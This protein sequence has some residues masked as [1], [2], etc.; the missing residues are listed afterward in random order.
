MQ[1]PALNKL[2]QE[3]PP[4]GKRFFLI[5]ATI[6]FL[7][8][9]AGLIYNFFILQGK[10]VADLD[11]G[12]KRVIFNTGDNAKQSQDFYSAENPPGSDFRS[13]LA[14]VEEVEASKIILNR[15]ETN[16]P[17]KVIFNITS[18]TEVFDLPED[19]ET[20]DVKAVSLNKINLDDLEKGDW[21]MVSYAKEKEDVAIGIY[22]QNHLKFE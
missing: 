14:E 2:P 5:A 20:G 21:V 19:L 7:L 16:P 6:I 4:A 1:N 3:A 15:Y 18:E 11:L 9:L 10:L 12:S 17:L 22:R 13:L 8:F